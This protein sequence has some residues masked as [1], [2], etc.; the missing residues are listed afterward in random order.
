LI[1]GKEKPLFARR[2]K[3]SNAITSPSASAS[4]FFESRVTRARKLNVKYLLLDF[5]VAVSR[6]RIK[7]NI[8]LSAYV[9]IEDSRVL[10]GN[11][12]VDAMEE[13]FAFYGEQ[14]PEKIS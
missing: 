1:E 5:T 6:S 7:K 3:P 8:L 2:L 9:N 13:S 10:S 4:T 14:E 12:I 11:F